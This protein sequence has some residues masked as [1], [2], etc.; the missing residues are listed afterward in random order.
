[1]FYA[2]PLMFYAF[3]LMFYAFPL[4][5]SFENLQFCSSFMGN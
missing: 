4:V 1:M 2:F 5:F 3:P